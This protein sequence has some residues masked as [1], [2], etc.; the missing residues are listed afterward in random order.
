[1]EEWDEHILEN[2]ALYTDLTNLEKP[3]NNQGMKHAFEMAKK[4]G[5]SL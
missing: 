2:W 5:K 3:F 4:R 1:M